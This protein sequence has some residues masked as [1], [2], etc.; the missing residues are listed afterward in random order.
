MRILG[1]VEMQPIKRKD[2]FLDGE[3]IYLRALLESDVDGNYPAWLNN[4]EVCRG[5]SHH[6]YPYS[7]EEAI[8]YIRQVQDN[9]N[10]LVLAVILKEADRHI[11]NI[12]LQSIRSLYGSAELSIII[13]E[14]DVWGCGY[15]KEAVHLI[16][17]H[18]FT[19]MNLHRIGCGTF[20]SNLA[21]QHVAEALGMKKE[22]IR[23][24]AAYKDGIYVDVIE[25]GLL[26]DEYIM[27]ENPG[28]GR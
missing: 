1:E 22:G 28:M 23:R 11:G 4:A 21:M 9:K 17:H 26:R 10:D 13:G 27:H 19:A 14:A 7:R 5:N 8:A 25:Y 18:G 12:A 16:C 6:V 3:H 2:V 15:A 24:Q 20:A